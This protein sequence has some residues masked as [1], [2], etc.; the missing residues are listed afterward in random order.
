[1]D[2]RAV[3]RVW[4]GKPNAGGTYLGT[5]FLISPDCLLTARHVIENSPSP[6]IYLQGQAWSGIRNLRDALCHDNPDIDVAILYL[7]KKEDRPIF[8]PLAPE[9]DADTGTGVGAKVMLAGFGTEYS[10]L[11]KIEATISSYD[12]NCDGCRGLTYSGTLVKVGVCTPR[13]PNFKTATA[14]ITPFRRKGK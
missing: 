1:M 13:P 4:F 14:I 12:G 11:E 6:E 2:D 8:L 10:D 3:A 9:Q 5:A 7:T